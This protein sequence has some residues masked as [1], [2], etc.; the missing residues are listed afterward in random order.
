VKIHRLSRDSW[1]YKLAYWYADV[2][3]P[4]IGRGEELEI[5]TALLVSR[6]LFG[7][8]GGVV[9]IAVE[10]L[11]GLIH[12]VGYLLFWPLRYA[13]VRIF[14]GRRLKLFALP[15]EEGY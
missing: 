10:I 12:L 5:D 4:A 13:C 3:P 11:I 7:L 8:T 6:I 9:L 2:V 15:G 1:S 14:T